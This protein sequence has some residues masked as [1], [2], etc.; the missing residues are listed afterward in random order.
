MIDQGSRIGIFEIPAKAMNGLGTPD[1]LIKYVSALEVAV[2][3]DMP[4]E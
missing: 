2:S 1:D 4:V 3:P